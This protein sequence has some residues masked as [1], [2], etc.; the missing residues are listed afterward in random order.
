[1][2]PEVTAE[3]FQRNIN[4]FPSEIFAKILSFLTDDDSALLTFE[5]TCCRWKLEAENH[6]VYV[7]KCRR[8]LSADPQLSPTFAQHRFE[9]DVQLNFSSS[10]KF[11]FRLKHLN[12]RWRRK[13]RVTVVDCL[14]AEVAGRK[15]KISDTWL[16]R[17]NYTG[18]IL[19][20]DLSKVFFTQS[21]RIRLA[22]PH[23]HS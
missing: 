19:D 23:L 9:A 6:R 10:K 5:L 20:F 18:K 14:Q 22:S 7:R 13:P 4:D 3:N 15:M 2:A 1:M 17:H 21:V 11:Y 8:M 12:G 16:Q